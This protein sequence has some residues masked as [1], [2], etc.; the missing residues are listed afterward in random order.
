MGVE[1]PGEGSDN[2][3]NPPPLVVASQQ[4]LGRCRQRLVRFLRQCVPQ[5]GRH[6][7]DKRHRIFRGKVVELQADPAEP[8]APPAAEPTPPPSPPPQSVRCRR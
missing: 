1:Y 3:L 8:V 7:V 4:G 2:R 5:T 6:R